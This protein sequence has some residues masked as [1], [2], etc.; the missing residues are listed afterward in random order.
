MPIQIKVADTSAKQKT[1]VDFAFRHYKGNKFWVP[2]LKKEEFKALRPEAN[3]A[4]EFCKTKFWI[5]YKDGI[6]AGRIGGIINRL[7]VEKTGE[8]IAR[9]TRFETIDDNEV[10]SG[11]LLAAESWAKENGMTAIHGP[12]GFSN[13]DHQGV[14]VEGFEYLPSIAS[15]YHQPFYQ[16]HFEQNGY[17]K[18]MDW[19]EFRLTLSAVPEKA[20][21]LNEAIKQRYGL[22]VRR[23]TSS[24]EVKTY[25]EKILDL[26]NE[27]FSDLF[28]MVPLKRK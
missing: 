27:A 1:F 18:E 23:F 2:S 22:T 17:Q 4:F 9:F 5:A 14:L 13:L 25:V 21:R 11:L 15:E 10:S 28:S 3:P 26:L 6:P 7:E 16:R 12:L 24:S 19:V 8:K 20:V